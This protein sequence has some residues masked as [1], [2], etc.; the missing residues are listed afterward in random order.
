VEDARLAFAG[1]VPQL[2][3]VTLPV[4]AILNGSWDLL[5]MRWQ[6]GL[7]A[8]MEDLDMW[9]GRSMARTIGRVR[10]GD[11]LS[12]SPFSSFYELQSLYL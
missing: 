11:P 9:E 3:A 12:T 10:E 4:V 8:K 1:L 5:G 2:A 7:K 6:T